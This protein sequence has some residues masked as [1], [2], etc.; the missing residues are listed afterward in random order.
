MCGIYGIVGPSSNA[1][2]RGSQIREM[3]DILAHRG[4]DGEGS[5]E[6]KGFLFGHRRLAIIDIEHGIQPMRSDDESITLVF[7]GEIYNYLELRQDLVRDG[8]RFKTHSDTE[9]LLRCYQRYGDAML[10]KLNGMFSFALFDSR[11]NLFFAARD[12]FGV[13]PFYFTVLN[14]GS[15]VFASEIKALFCVPEIKKK[16]D[17]IGL[18]EYL[19]FQFCL[20]E[21]TLFNGIKKLLPGHSI[22]MNVG[23]KNIKVRKWWHPSFEIETN[24]NSEYFKDKLN[25]LIHDSIRG[26][27]RGDVPVGGHLSGGL[28]SSIVVSSAVMQYGSGF[29]SF[30]GKF[31]E[32]LQYDETEYARIVAEATGCDNHEITIGPGDFE[33]SFKKLIYHMDEP[34][35]GPGLLPQYIVSRYAKKEVSVVLGGQGGDELFGGYARYLIAYLEQCLKGGIFETQEEGAHIV[36]LESIIPNLPMLKN[37]V[38]MLTKFWDSGLFEPMENR[39]FKLV[40]KGEHLRRI[41]NVDVTNEFNDE[42]IWDSFQTIFNASGSRSYLNKMTYFDQNT[43]LPS[44][45]HV[46][47]RVSMAVSLESRVPLLDFRIAELAATMPPAIKYEGGRAKSILK[48]S[49]ASIL[50]ERILARED[51]MGFPVPLKD[52]FSGPLKDFVGD[53]LYSKS[54]RERGFFDNKKMA[55]L[56]GSEPQ[57]GREIWGALCLE[58]WFQTFFDAE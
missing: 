16:P 36:D 5:A 45:L 25:Y 21:R 17:M 24:R 42:L 31:S 39:Y 34:A 27:L 4:P 46:E 51:K 28:D 19:T 54:C 7:N 40:D 47:D 13:K 37:Y 32:G 11:K 10:E 58:I 2:G 20:N 52:W 53:I 6:G 9:V 57:Y 1:Q 18:H 35:A 26:Q 38:P 33:N 29:K 22:S 43:L 50:P 15:L 14:D 56:S 12:H 48:E 8:V 30:T 41:V 44:L 49:M 3:G 55:K 23:D